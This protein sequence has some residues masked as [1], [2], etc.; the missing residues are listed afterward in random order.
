MFGLQYIKFDTMDHIIHYQNGKV[1]REGKGLSFFYFTPNSSIVKVP[2]NSSDLRF[3]FTEA[4][5][6]FQQVTVQGQITYRIAEPAKAAALLNFTVNEN[7]KY[8]SEDFEKLEQRL[9][10]EAQAAV[11]SFVLKMNLRDAITS[12]G[13][14][15]Q[16]I[17]NGLGAS[18]VVNTLGLEILSVN[19]FDVKASPEMAKALEAQTREAL[20]QEADKAIYDR[21]NFA[22][23]QERKI[24][25]S[26]LNTEIAVEEKQKQIAQKQ[27][28]TDMAKQE[29]KR[30]I[31]EMEMATEIAMEEERK[32]LIDA[33]VENERK[34][35]D[36]QEYVLTANL[37]PYK[38][39]DW[40]TLMAINNKNFDP[41]V[42]MALAFREMAE[43]ANKI[44]TLNLTPDLLESIINTK[45]A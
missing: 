27:M 32:R 25:E 7:K 13:P 17:I 9:I 3:I 24:K 28:E 40:K 16:E 44:G 39:I 33:K 42:H 26:E 41:K 43:N 4:T 45:N 11:S 36:A 18:K 12:I 22:V 14:V 37:K 23:E 5:K 6:D 30:K 35:A 2:M 21:R 1:K 29:K 8:L 34:K 20:Q 31:G 10:N 38:D 19:V 15:E